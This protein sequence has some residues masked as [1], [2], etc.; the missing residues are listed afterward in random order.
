M[1]S[2]LVR[3]GEMRYKRYKR[4]TVDGLP[5]PIRLFH[6][7]SLSQKEREFISNRQGARFERRADSTHAPV[8]WK[9]CWWSAEGQRD[10]GIYVRGR[11]G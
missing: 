3:V 9:G 5:E 4:V 8:V 2:K 10:G 1:N 7:Y 11:T 6:E